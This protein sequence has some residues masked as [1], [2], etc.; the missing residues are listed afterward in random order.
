MLSQMR[1]APPAPA[2]PP[3]GA[4]L[5]ASPREVT[6]RDDCW[7][8]HTIDLP[9]HG[10]IEGHWDLRAGVDDY[11]GHVPLQGKRVL[12]IG[13]ASGYLCFHM[14]RHGAN[15]VAFDI[16]EGQL[17]DFVPLVSPRELDPYVERCARDFRRLHNSFWLGHRVTGSRAQVVHGNIYTLPPDIGPVDVVTFGSVLLHL[18]DP[19]LALANGVRFA[20]E[21]VIVTQPLS[22]RPF[23]PCVMGQEYEAWLDGAGAEFIPRRQPRGWRAQLKSLFGLR[24]LR[25]A[26]DNPQVPCMVFLPDA[27][28]P[29]LLES[30]WFL[31]PL[32][33]QQF[34]GTLGFEE[35]RVSYH[36]Q[37]FEGRRRPLY[38]VVARRT[39]PMP[40]RLDGSYPWI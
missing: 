28:T 37:I 16:A 27:Q 6:S 7:F 20:R 4:N 31:T 25:R 18:R 3:Q 10:V 23:E 39:R 17:W 38:T 33:V 5:Y 24:R 22:L 19:F 11:L 40:S 2:L 21:T 9:G 1:L 13:T 29:S 36:A 14:E 35:S 32:V 15:V 8:Y 12:E 30:W 26:P 34:L